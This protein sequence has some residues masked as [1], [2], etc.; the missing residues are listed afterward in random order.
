[1]DS[2]KDRASAFWTMTRCH[3]SEG[4]RRRG[5]PLIA[6]NIFEIMWR[7]AV[8]GNLS[9]TPGFPVI[10]RHLQVP[11]TCWLTNYIGLHWCQRR[12]QRSGTLISYFAYLTLRWRC[13]LQ[14]SFTRYR[15][16]LVIY[17]STTNP[18]KIFSLNTNGGYWGSRFFNFEFIY[19]FFSI[20]FEKLKPL[21]KTFQNEYVGLFKKST[22]HEATLVSKKIIDLLRI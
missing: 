10:I 2:I 19:F 20:W 18:A 7:G 9:I 15:D 5:G 17:D 12:K 3:D 8:L 13:K 14:L 1:M 11:W 6:R 16:G 4:K 22:L 21:L